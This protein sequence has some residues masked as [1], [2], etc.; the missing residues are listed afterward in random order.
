V[1]E[2]GRYGG[3]TG[4]ET[5][6][7][8]AVSRS[9]AHRYAAWLDE[10]RVG[11]LILSVLVAALCAFLGSRMPLDSNLSTLLP[12]SQRSVTDL[13]AV[14]ARA[15]PFSSV[16]VV[17][18]AADPAVRARAAA[19]L[20][21]RL[22]AALPPELVIQFTTDD[23]PA[24][25]YGWT[26]RFLF[27]E[28]DDLVAAR[29]ALDERIQA[30]KLAAN[31]L[32]VPLDDEDDA[33]AAPDRLAELEAE[34]AAAEAKATAPPGKVSAD[35]ALQ[36]FTI[37][38]S[39][40]ASAHHKARRLLRIVNREIRAVRAEV[41]GP[42][43]IGL[44]GNAAM[45]VHEHDSALEGMWLSALITVLLVGIAL[46]LYYR[47]GLLVLSML[48]ALGVGVAAT[49][50]GARFLI[51]HLDMMSAFLAAIVVGNGINAALILV[52]RYLE[53]VRGERTPTE[54]VAHAIAGALRGTTAAM[55]TAVV[56]YVSLV[57]TDFRGFRNFG[58][59]AG[60][61][62]LLTFASTFI[63]LP[64]LLFVL[65]R[66]GKIRATRTPAIGLVLARLLPRR[67]S[68]VVVA[69]AVLTVAG[70]VVTARFIANDP[71]TKDWRDLQSSTPAIN[72][73][74][75][76]DQELRA[77][78]EAKS[79]MAGQAYMTVIAVDR[80]DQVLPLVEKIRAEEAARPPAERWLNDVRSLDD[81]LPRDQDEKLAVLAEI[82]ALLDGDAVKEALSPE[83]LTRLAKVRPPD[84]LRVLTDA[85]VPP[86]LAWPFV[87]RDGSV[88]RLIVL[89]GSRQLRS[90]DVADRLRFAR[91]VRAID[92][93]PGT[94]VAGEALVVAD[95][96][97]TMEHDAPLMVL[98]ALCGSIIAI[99]LVIGLGR[100]GAVTLVCGLA[101]V[102]LMVAAC[103]IAGLKVHFL[104]LI[105][106]PLTI[107]IGIDYA[108]N[109]AARDRQ[110]G[111]RGPHHLLRTT[112]GAVL[113]CSYTTAVGYGTLLLSANGGIRAFGLA[114]LIGEITTLVMALLVAPAL[115]ALL[116][117]RVRP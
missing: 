10:N 77:A 115:L 70:A 116:R 73:G 42:V 34:L 65:G 61:G 28:L 112:G 97:A 81:F 18:K 37:Q 102:I 60:T 101:G 78:F 93:P 11:V 96:I 108:A 4:G 107:G 57:I 39:F 44:T 62:M 58:A 41:G 111:E 54:A 82:R 113:M 106:L 95:I 33:E 47:S 110:D 38:A 104:D 52:A 76:L 43:Q 114:A 53:E 109:L 87:E 67:L 46:Y 75:A 16:H 51:G 84:D 7:T 50:A 9:A 64:A 22:V 85:D 100:H 25:R 83:E 21:D 105:A 32:Y 45:T 74:R 56:A 86:E 31:P 27:A 66:R 63:V 12:R 1:A 72:V 24:Q 103:S 36:L 13:A 26:N 98:F 89:R 59:I 91:E 49:F 14:Q 23:G 55:A 5:V 20:R 8:P 17:I 68:T 69:G 48:W 99:A 3:A 88:G 40:P 6:Y 80:R 15:R 35:G 71:F 90:F 2:T 94:V 30:A 19:L 117:Q 79:V 92:L 29:D